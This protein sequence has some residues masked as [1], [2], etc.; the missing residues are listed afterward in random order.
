MY[1]RKTLNFDLHFE[2]HFWLY[3]GSTFFCAHHKNMQGELEVETYINAE[4]LLRK[5]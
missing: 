5:S 1:R 2:L 3:A 4:V